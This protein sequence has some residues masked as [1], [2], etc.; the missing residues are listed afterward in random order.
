MKG[1]KLLLLLLPLL[2]GYSC[3]N[4]PNDKTK[5]PLQNSHNYS[6]SQN[7]AGTPDTPN[8]PS[9]PL[10]DENEETDP[11]T[12][13]RHL[14]QKPFEVIQQMGDLKGKIVADIGAGPVGYFSI[15]IAAQGDV[16]KIIAID[17][18]AKAIEYIENAKKKWPRK[19]ERIETRL[20]EPDDPKLK[21]GEADIVLIVN[22]AIFFEDRIAYFNNLRKG[23]APGGKLVIIDYKM[24]NTPVGPPVS[25]RIPLGQ[26]EQDLAAAGYTKINSDDRTLE[27]QYI[28]TA[29]I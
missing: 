4:E 10:I 9:N 12:L 17:I 15:Q 29:G 16:E 1:S 8:A 23:L 2:F 11:L 7:N 27:Y 13:Y 24:R 21:E 18:D 5:H 20:V 3:T 25:S 22:T 6:D 14:W 26:M 28:V 19:L